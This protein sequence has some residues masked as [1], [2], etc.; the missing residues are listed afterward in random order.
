ALIPYEIIPAKHLRESLLQLGSWVV[1]HGIDGD[2]SYQAARDLLLRRPPRLLG[3]TLRDLST[4]NQP[5]I[6]VAKQVAL[7]LDHTVLPI[8]GPPGSGKTYTGARM[9][10]ELVRIGQRVGIT[11]VS[12]KVISNLLEESCK[13]ARE[14]RINLRAIQKA[15]LGDCCDDEMVTRAKDNESVAEALA[16]GKAMVAAGTV[17]LWSR[18]EMADSVDVLFVDEAGQMSLANVLAA[19]PAARSVVLLGDPQQLDQPQR[20]VHPPGAE[21][22]ALSHLLNGRATI[23]DDQG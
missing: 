4:S 13:A 6:E 8:Q 7:A 1:D 12:H 2:G 3:S 18:P 15:D 20:G 19:S 22:S 17:W 10:A 9:I 14:S 5:P 16:D 21:A 23:G 11:A